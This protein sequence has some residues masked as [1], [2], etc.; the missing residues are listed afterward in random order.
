MLMRAMVQP[1]FL[2]EQAL[3]SRAVHCGADANIGLLG[4]AVHVDTETLDIPL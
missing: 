1:E 3:N 4:L 2:F